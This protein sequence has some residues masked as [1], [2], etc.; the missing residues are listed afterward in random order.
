M[1]E[2][3]EAM[4]SYIFGKYDMRKGEN[5]KLRM[6]K[7][8]EF[9]MQDIDEHPALVKELSNKNALEHYVIQSIIYMM[10]M[11]VDTDVGKHNYV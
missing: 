5:N 9:C 8:T 1:K 7:L 4:I 6:Q 2:K 11:E 3:V 10:V